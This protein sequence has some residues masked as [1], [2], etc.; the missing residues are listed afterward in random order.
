MDKILWN[1]KAKEIK[2]HQ[3]QELPGT[4]RSLH[5]S[6]IQIRS[7]QQLKVIGPFPRIPAQTSSRTSL[8]TA[9]PKI[10]LC[11]I[12]KLFLSLVKYA[13][14]FAHFYYIF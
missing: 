7:P 2:S 5:S 12:H 11:R 14:S 1:E 9:Y 8:A 10:M 13:V 6:E 4:V 3:L